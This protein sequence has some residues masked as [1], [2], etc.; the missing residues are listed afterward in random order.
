MGVS[1]AAVEPAGAK[2]L[3]REASR[4][5]T[6]EVNMRSCASDGVLGPAVTYTPALLLISTR[7]TWPPRSA[8]LA[9]FCSAGK[10]PA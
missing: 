10:S 5:V 3:A 6:G 1:P 2:A 8:A 4:S 7:V 9:T